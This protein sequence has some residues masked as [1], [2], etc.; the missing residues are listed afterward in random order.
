MKGLAEREGFSLAIF[1]KLLF[2]NR[3]CANRL[4]DSMFRS[5]H[6]NHLLHHDHFGHL[7]FMF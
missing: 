7:D 1:C 2:S 3:L 4:V 5:R 6:R